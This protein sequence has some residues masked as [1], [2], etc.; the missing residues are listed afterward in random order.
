MLATVVLTHTI[1][2]TVHT[3]LSRSSIGL[4]ILYFPK[5]TLP[6]TVEALLSKV[7][8]A[9]I[10]IHVEVVWDQDILHDDCT[11][12]GKWCVGLEHFHHIDHW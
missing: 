7:E 9:A 11:L 3:V 8:R 6:T 5:L 1:H 2:T 10:C 4:G 12:W